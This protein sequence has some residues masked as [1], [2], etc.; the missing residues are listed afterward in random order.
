MG[1]CFWG[2]ERWNKNLEGSERLGFEVFPGDMMCCSKRSTFLL[3]PNVRFH[4]S[5]SSSSKCLNREKH[6]AS[7][8]LPDPLI[9]I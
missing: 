9:D 5:Q 8:K 2:V 4:L 3:S 6:S 7:F 1:P